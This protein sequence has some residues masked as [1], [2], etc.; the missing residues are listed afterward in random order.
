MQERVYV[1][2]YCKI[3]TDNFSDEM[4][5]KMATGSEIYEFLMKDAD[6]CY[7]DK[8][9]IIPG[10]SN[11]WYLGCNEKCGCLVYEN[12]ISSWGLGESSFK[13]VRLF[14][15]IMHR[16]GLFTREQY[17]NLIKKIREGRRI[18]DMYAIDDYLIS[19]REGKPWYEIRS[20]FRDIIKRIIPKTLGALGRKCFQAYHQ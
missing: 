13:R 9:E 10:D 6:Q 1:N 3:H 17:H 4:V 14:V 7:D 18:N 15:D 2:I 20:G 11:I 19:K 12:N 8:G 16:D 5:E